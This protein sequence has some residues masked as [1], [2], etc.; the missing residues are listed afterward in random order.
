MHLLLK[1][2]LA[3]FLNISAASIFSWET[4]LSFALFE[5]IFK[6]IVIIKIDKSY[7]FLSISAL[8][9]YQFYTQRSIAMRK[10][11][12]RTIGAATLWLLNH[13]HEIQNLVPK[14]FEFN[15]FFAP[16]NEFTT[17]QNELRLVQVFLKMCGTKL[18][19]NSYKFCPTQLQV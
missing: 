14:L 6:V 2:S 13:W 19:S 18:W 1:N 16:T 15:W 12:N 8:R 7:E 9:F 17:V 10:T 3:S 11:Q 4:L 5:D